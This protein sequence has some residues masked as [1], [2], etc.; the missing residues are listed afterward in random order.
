MLYNWA[1]KN[2]MKLKANNFELRNRTGNKISNNLNI[3]WWYK[4]KEHV[5]DLSIMMSNRATFTLH[6]R[7]IVQKAGDKIGW[8]LR[9]FQSR[10]LLLCWH[11]WNLL[12]LKLPPLESIEDKRYTSYRSYSTNVYMQNHWS[13]A[14]KLLGKTARTQI[15][16]SPETP[17][18]LYY[19]IYL[20][21]T[22]HMLPNMDGTMGHKY[23]P[24]KHTR[25]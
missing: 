17:W 11:F 15:I 2:N 9:V 12:A 5:R 19:Y 13:T 3:I 21:D 24:R 8:V 16:L 10:C 1:D 20:E 18:T 14:I 6:I 23:K 4:C 7:N 25:H 22:Q